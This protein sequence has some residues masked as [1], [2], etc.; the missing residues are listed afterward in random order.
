MTEEV[1]AEYS[2][3]S[4]SF[5]VELQKPTKQLTVIVSEFLLILTRSDFPCLCQGKGSLCF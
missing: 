3:L 5:C 2:L 1:W 4:L